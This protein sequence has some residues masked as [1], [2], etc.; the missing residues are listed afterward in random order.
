MFAREPADLRPKIAIE[1]PGDPQGR[2]RDINGFTLTADIQTLY[3]G[4]SFTIPNPDG[5]FNY[6]LGY[7]LQPIRIWHSD[8]AVKG[9]E[10]RPWYKGVIEKVEQKFTEQG[11]V[12]E[13]S[14]YD[15][16]WY[17]TS[18]APYW[19]RLRGLSWAELCRKMLDP[20]WGVGYVFE[21]NFAVQLKQGR[22]DAETRAYLTQA[23]QASSQ[24]SQGR[25]DVALA[26]FAKF[27]AMLPVIQVMPGETVGDIITRYAKLAEGPGKPGALVNMHPD[28]NLCIFRPDYNRRPDY[29]F[30]L[31]KDGHPEAHRTNV[32]QPRYL[33][34]GGQIWN[35]VS[36][37][38]T[39]IVG[40]TMPNT[41]DPNEDKFVGRYVNRF[42]TK[43]IEPFGD[44]GPNKESLRAAGPPQQA[45]L[46]RFAFMDPDRL[47]GKQAKIRAQWRF[48]QGVYGR[49]TL[50]YV[51]QG[52]SQRRPEGDAIP[53]VE[54]TMAEVH[55]SINGIDG[56]WYVARVMPVLPADAG[57]HTVITL[58]PPGLLAA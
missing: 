6:M 23:K 56:K 9:G 42:I 27:K 47:T 30:H 26:L 48:D 57:S 44:V 24:I 50:T 2:R 15:N 49:E 34:D 20:S 37:I 36:C 51:H 43:P 40:L 25:S 11:T 17:L 53:F 32:Y 33:R 21:G 7:E 58:K 16:G 18:H 5:H 8:P 38:G 3:D 29:V 14:G 12:L 45:P 4:W 52:H 1:I 41:A 19:T 22:A 46:R 13:F 35:D 54:G 28:G 39:R 31:H 55:D 10:E